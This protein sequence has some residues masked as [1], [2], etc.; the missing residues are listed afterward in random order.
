ME[1]SVHAGNVTLTGSAQGTDGAGMLAEIRKIDGVKEVTD[2]IITQEVLTSCSWRPHHEHIALVQDGAGHH[3]V[4]PVGTAHRA[5]REAGL[6]N[7][8]PPRHST[9][10]RPPRLSEA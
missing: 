4:S 8:S 6:R 7:A 9:A 1:V 5:T 2:Q 3:G 10:D